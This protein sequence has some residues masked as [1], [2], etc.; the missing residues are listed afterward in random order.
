MRRRIQNSRWYPGPVFMVLAAIG[1]LQA[2][3]ATD[4]SG[5]PGVALSYDGLVRLE[6]TIMSQVWVREGFKLGGYNKV[7][8]INAGIRYRPM[9]TRNEFPLT[10]R[11]KQTFQNL[12]SEE[13]D[14]ALDRLV[15]EQVSEPGPDVL[16]VRGFMLDVVST[17]PPD[18]PGQD[19][20]W[21]D[22][23]G[24]ATFVVELVDSQSNAVL[25]RA[26]DTRAAKTP[27]QSR[28]P[29]SG[30]KG[31]EVRRLAARWADMLVDALNDLTAIDEFKGA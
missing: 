17:P 25:I 18:T 1:S 27:G 20:Y 21:L 3:C 10:E 26:L 22:S 28:Q 6:G 23:V 29:A 11:Q 9:P 2:G 24:Q 30:A 14:K 5:D 19:D 4:P 13:F 15:L 31:A 16:L 7:M 12:I 8:L